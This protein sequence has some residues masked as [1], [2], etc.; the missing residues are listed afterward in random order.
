MPDPSPDPT[1]PHDLEARVRRLEESVG[2]NEHTSDQLAGEV[3]SAHAAL[4]RLSSRLAALE[5]R[6]ASIEDGGEDDPDDDSATDSD[7]DDPAMG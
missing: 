3:A 2:F 1:A 4:A 7:L 6:L 5:S